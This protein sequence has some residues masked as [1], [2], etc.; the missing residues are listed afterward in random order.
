MVEFGR[1]IDGSVDPQ[2]ASGGFCPPQNLAE[3]RLWAP[4]ATAITLQA[5]SDTG[6]PTVDNVPLTHVIDAPGWWQAVDDR[7]PAAFRTAMPDRYGF[8]IDDDRTPLPDPRSTRLPD[9]V[10]QSGSAYRVDPATWRV[11]EAYRPIGRLYGDRYCTT[12]QRF[13]LP[14]PLPE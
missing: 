3:V 2:F 13:D 6:S 12:R 11:S 8:C 10:H 4:R 5:H 14:G 7:I 9:G 1:T